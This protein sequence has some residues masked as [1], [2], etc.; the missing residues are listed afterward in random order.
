V[1]VL[2]IGP[3]TLLKPVLVLLNRYLTSIGLSR[4]SIYELRGVVTN[5]ILLTLLVNITKPGNVRDHLKVD[6]DV[7]SALELRGD[8]IA[9]M[10]IV[11]NTAL[12]ALAIRIVA[13]I[14]L[15]TRKLV[16]GVRLQTL[17]IRKAEVN[18]ALRARSDTLRKKHD[19]L[20]DLVIPKK[21]S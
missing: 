1:Y 17:N 4:C 15:V 3:T 20:L 8:V 19:P 18:I 12:Q 9:I 10:I 6:Q 21:E 7:N 13:L 16:S 11:A 5:T 14:K 2:I